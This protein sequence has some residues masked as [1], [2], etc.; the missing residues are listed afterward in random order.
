MGPGIPEP[1]KFPPDSIFP[2]TRRTRFPK[3]FGRVFPDPFDSRDQYLKI[4]AGYF[5]E[6]SGTFLHLNTVFDT[7]GIFIWNFKFTFFKQ[8]PKFDLF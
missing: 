2:H 1:E 8:Y 3:T 5:R 6:F 7:K 4:L